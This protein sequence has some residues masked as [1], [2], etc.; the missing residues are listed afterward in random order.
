[1]ITSTR[2]DADEICAPGNRA[3]SRAHS[4]IHAAAQPASPANA[5]AAAGST[6]A[7]IAAASPRPSN[8]ATAGSASA[9]ANTVQS[10]TRWKSS[11][12]IGLVTVPQAIE[13]AIAARS[14]LGSRNG[15]GRSSS[16]RSSQGTQT[17]IAP[18]AANESWKPGSSRVAGSRP[19]AQGLRERESASDP[20]ASKPATLV[21]RGFPRRR[22]ERRK[23]AT[24][25]P[26]YRRRSQ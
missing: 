22:P 6:G 20:L 13:T 15:R 25:Q 19:G 8:G 4:A 14:I 5:T 16:R 12:R 24:R 9:F 18:T 10:G 21:T 3:T 26:T 2:T 17:K 7:T 11:H 1:M 23:A